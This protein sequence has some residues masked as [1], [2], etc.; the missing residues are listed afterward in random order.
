MS[1]KVT[2][3][4]ALLDRVD[5][6]IRLQA[7]TSVAGFESQKDKIIFLGSAGL[8]PKDIAEILGTTANTVNV[9][10]ARSRKASKNKG[11]K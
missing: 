3:E 6:L 11:K 2:L 5:I 10:L 4:Q 9:T 8:S 7:V 1:N